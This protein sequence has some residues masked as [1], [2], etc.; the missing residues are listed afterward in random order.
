M[1]ENVRHG[2]GLKNRHAV[3]REVVLFE[4][5]KWQVQRELA[6]IGAGRYSSKS[7]FPMSVRHIRLL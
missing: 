7:R 3:K 2:G 6:L 5:G 1:R 4:R